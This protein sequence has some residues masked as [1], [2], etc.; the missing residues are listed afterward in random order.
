MTITAPPAPGPTGLPLV[1]HML[2]LKRDPLQL[3]LSSSIATGD[4]TRLTAGR[5]QVFLLRNPDYIKYVL[6]DNHRNYD[7][8]T[9][10]YL[11]LK[12]TL[13]DGLLTAEGS[14]WQRQ[15]RIMQPAFHRQRLASFADLMARAAADSVAHWRTIPADQPVDI[16]PEL[17]RVTLKILGGCM[18]GTDISGDADAIGNA[19]TVVLESTIGRVQGIFHVP[20]RIPT[21]ANQRFREAVALFDRLVYDRITTR[22]RSGDDPGDLLSMLMNA[23]DEETGEAMTDRQLRDELVTIISAGHETTANA[24]AWTVYLLSKH[25]YVRRQVESEV[26]SVLGDRLPGFTDLPKLPY[27]RSVIEESMRLFPPAW[28]VARRAVSD[29][30]IGGY[31][32]TKNAYVMVSPWVMQRDPR[33][34]E[35]PEG[36]DPGRF[37]P[38]MDAGRPRYAYFPFGGGPHLCIGNNL[39]MME[40]V[41]VLATFT[42]SLRMDL[43][44]GHPV[45]PEPMI[46]LR[47]RH[48]VKVWVRPRTHTPVTDS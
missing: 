11:A 45:V 1:G 38:G 36:F 3:F 29:D 13:G 8:Q 2:D 14:Y 41:L 42:R 26:D 31:A 43:V 22:R 30:V 25:P 23:R 12:E 7:R 37:A 34:W 32:I 15:R 33:Y 20:R 47:P 19:V 39:A 5:V 48:G 6:Q 44:P 27:T 18:F 24:L 35:N 16:V 9:R 4:V 10:G 21:P 40:A 46:T 17:L 28:V